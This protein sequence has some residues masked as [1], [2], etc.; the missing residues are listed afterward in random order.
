MA[1]G[2]EWLGIEVQGQ[3]W[4]IT[5]LDDLALY[6]GKATQVTALVARDRRLL[7]LPLALQRPTGNKRKASAPEQPDTV[8][9]AITDA[10]RAARWL[11]G[12]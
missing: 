8:T 11:D 4:R 2:D 10:A 3:G 7:R 6:A 5:Q 12:H 9:L 1:P